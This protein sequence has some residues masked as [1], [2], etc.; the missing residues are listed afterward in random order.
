MCVCVIYI[1]QN[2]KGEFYA[3]ALFVSGFVYCAANCANCQLYIVCKESSTMIQFTPLEI[4]KWHAVLL[5]IHFRSPNT[6]ISVFVNQNSY[7]YT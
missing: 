4:W 1:Q 6:K 7:S 5:G 3:C 2:V